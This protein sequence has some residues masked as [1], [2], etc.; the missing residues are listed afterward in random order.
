LFLGFFFSSRRRHTRFSRDWSSDVCS[1]DL[2]AHYDID[3]VGTVF[4]WRAGAQYAPI[5]A[6]RFR[7]QFARAQRA[8]DIAELYS[9]PRGN[10]E[11]ANDLCDGVT[12]TTAGRI[13]A[14]C[15]LDPG[16][17]ALFAQQATDGATQRY[18]QA[19]NSLYSPNGG[20]LDLKEETADTLTLGA[21]LAPRF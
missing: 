8:P 20:N 4:S 13:A 6:I 9:P 21:V 14:G 19:G 3:R 11:A 5:E 18:T 7:A 2:V 15:R 12:P 1:S 10:F 17:Q 16:I